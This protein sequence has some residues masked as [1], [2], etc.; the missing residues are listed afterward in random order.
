MK[1]FWDKEDPLEIINKKYLVC[2]Y[3]YKLQEIQ[4]IQYNRHSV[5]C[6]FIFSSVYLLQKNVYNKTMLCYT[7]PIAN[8]ITRK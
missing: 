7:D 6:L 1:F 5:K 8:I 2:N 3:S 4:V